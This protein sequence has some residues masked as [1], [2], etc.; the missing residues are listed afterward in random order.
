[1]TLVVSSNVA[2]ANTTGVQA[3]T[4]D[5][6]TT[7]DN[8]GTVDDKIKVSLENIREIM[9]ENNLDI[10][11]LNNELKIARE[12]YKNINDTVESDNS[13]VT[14]A[15]N[16]KAKAKLDYDNAV[17]SNDG[18]ADSKLTIYTTADGNLTTANSNLTKAKSDLTTAKDK[19]KTANDNYENGVESKILTAEQD[20]MNYLVTLSEKQFQQDTAK[21][22]ERDAK[23][24]KI[25]YDSGFISNKEYVNST[26]T[27]TESNDTL[28]KAINDEAL[29]KTKLCNEL[30]VS[31]DDIVINTDI[32]EEF[33]K[34][35]QI[36]YNKDL[37]TML[38]NS[39]SVQAASDNVDN[40]D[41][42]DDK[43]DNDSDYT[44]EIDNYEMDNAKIELKKSKMKA[45]EDFKAQYN[46]LMNSYNSTKSS[47]DKIIQKQ[48]EFQTNQI[49][50]DYGFLSK[51][52]TDDAEV[53]FE[54][55]SNDFIKMRNAC[56]VEYLKYIQMKEGY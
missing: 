51:N 40:L 50:Y 41:E 15:Q 55:N 35:S 23:I 10:K 24:L 4:T 29:Q 5:S 9:T 49:K 20:Y 38:D 53:T 3:A 18:T 14:S 56:Y 48:K 17:A 32:N 39:K 11:L 30:G 36:N 28:K 37:E 6:T 2:L 31:E 44:D 42:I 45:E 43:T 19:R 47:Y 46:T 27:N 52:D 8:T 12:N 13:S 54:K 25:K 22:T 34:I 7:V 33:I 16:A 21:S 26:I 1:M